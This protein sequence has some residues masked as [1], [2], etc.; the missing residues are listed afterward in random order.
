MHTVVDSFTTMDKCDLLIHFLETESKCL[1]NFSILYSNTVRT[2]RKF[3]LLVTCLKPMFIRKVLEANCRP[4]SDTKHSRMPCRAK[5]AFTFLMT[6]FEVVVLNDKI[7]ISN[8]PSGCYLPLKK[9]S[10]HSL[11]RVVWERSWF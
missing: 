1:R 4:L 7:L 6:P 10:C 5:I 8:Q 11:P 2:C 9:I 3:W